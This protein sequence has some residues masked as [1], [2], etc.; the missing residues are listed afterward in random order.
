MIRFQFI[1]GVSFICQ[2]RININVHFFKESNVSE[3]SANATFACEFLFLEL[4]RR[5]AVAKFKSSLGR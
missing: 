4:N 2:N 3:V 5:L 1:I